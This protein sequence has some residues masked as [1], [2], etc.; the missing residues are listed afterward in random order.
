MKYV[1]C[2]WCIPEA[3]KR[4]GKCDKDRKGLMKGEVKTQRQRDEWVITVC[5][6]QTTNLRKKLH[7]VLLKQL[8][9]WEGCKTS[10]PLRITTKPSSTNLGGYLLHTKAELGLWKRWT[11]CKQERLL[12]QFNWLSYSRWFKIIRLMIYYIQLLIFKNNL[13][14]PSSTYSPKAVNDNNNKKN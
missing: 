6:P 12:E 4:R 13:D 11:F 10:E 9:K 8:R 5:I 3:K 14:R 1:F 2:L 7:I